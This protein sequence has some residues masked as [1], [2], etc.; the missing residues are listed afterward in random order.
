M[1]SETEGGYL[2]IHFGNKADV[3]ICQ[4]SLVEETTVKN[5]LP[6]TISLLGYEH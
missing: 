6:L 5:S 4:I 1:R 2:D 3:D